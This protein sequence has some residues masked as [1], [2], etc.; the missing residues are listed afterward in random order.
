M[1]INNTQIFK[2]SKIWR[3][4]ENQNQTIQRGVVLKV[5]CVMYNLNMPFPC[6]SGNILG[7]GDRI[8][9]PELKFTKLI[10]VIWGIW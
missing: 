2:K 7:L 9:F 1:L 5:I 6:S 4:V 10:V 3:D 8:Y